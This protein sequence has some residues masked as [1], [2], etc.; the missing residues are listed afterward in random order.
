MWK[1]GAN[2]DFMRKLLV[3]TD[4]SQALTK[5]QKMQL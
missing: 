3:E 1:T 5:L 2:G 4:Q